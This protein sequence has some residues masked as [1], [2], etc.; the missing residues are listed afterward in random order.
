MRVLCP[1]PTPCARITCIIT[2]G[3]RILL[4]FG[5]HARLPFFFIRLGQTK[6]VSASTNPTDR[7][8]KRR[9]DTFFRLRVRYFLAP[10]RTWPV[11]SSIAI[12]RELEKSTSKSSKGKE[13]LTVDPG[14]WATIQARVEMCDATRSTQRHFCLLQ[15]IVRHFPSLRLAASTSKLICRSFSL[16]LA[17]S[18]SPSS[19]LFLVYSDASGSIRLSTSPRPGSL[20][21]EDVF[22]TLLG[23]ASSRRANWLIVS[24]DR[25]G[26]LRNFSVAPN[27]SDHKWLQ[28]FGGKGTKTLSYPHFHVP[29]SKQ[30]FWSLS[31]FP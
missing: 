18:F 9:P 25:H 10:L 24:W 7:V 11:A 12:T 8:L 3:E 29:L 23:L 27:S 5:L 28:M 1:P 13:I 31:P 20:L 26:R 30:F 22:C 19:Q 4:S 21:A 17:D 14:F 2:R 16:F 15:Q 6:K